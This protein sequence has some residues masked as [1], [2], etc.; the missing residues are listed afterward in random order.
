M[1]KLL[2]NCRYGFDK[3]IVKILDL[4]LLLKGFYKFLVRFL[5]FFLYFMVFDIILFF[6]VFYEINFLNNV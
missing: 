4:F 2:F 6:F 1:G 3:E 5:S